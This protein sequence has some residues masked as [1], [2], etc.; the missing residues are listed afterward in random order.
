MPAHL[1]P[2]LLDRVS[3][4]GRCADSGGERRRALQRAHPSGGLCDRLHSAGSRADSGLDPRL[5]EGKT[6]THHY[7]VAP[8]SPS[9][10]P[11]A[12][13]QSRAGGLG[14]AEDVREICSRW[15]QIWQEVHRATQP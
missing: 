2:G 8:G 5:S 6:S 12:E 10:C 14:Q 9:S 11:G 13:P 7:E 15:M 4:W 1:A 3:W